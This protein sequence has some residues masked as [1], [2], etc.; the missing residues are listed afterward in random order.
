L[1]KRFALLRDS[2]WPSLKAQT[3][4][5]FKLVGLSAQAMPVWHQMLLTGLCKDELG[6]ARAEVFFRKPGLANNKFRDIIRHNYSAPPVSCQIVLDDDDALA[7]DFIARL[8]PE[9]EAAFSACPPDRQ[10][11]F[12]SFPKG[13]TLRLSDM[14]AQLYHRDRAFTN[15]GLAQIAPTT[16]QRTIVGVA[17]KRIPQRHLARIVYDQKPAY[18]RT[19]HDT[20]DS[21]APFRND[22][23]PAADLPALLPLFPGLT[24]FFPD[25]AAVPEGHGRTSGP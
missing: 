21:R 1:N 6:D 24:R 22:P 18:L 2:A 10:Q 25:L 23:V 19:V 4:E 9:A 13:F 14:G 16:L 8:R 3:D 5:E 17:H 20:N 7:S 11:V 12:V 15:L